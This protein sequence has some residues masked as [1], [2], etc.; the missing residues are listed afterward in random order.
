M[1]VV[2]TNVDAQV[3]LYALARNERTM[4]TAMERLSTG[5]RVNSAAD[6]PAGLQMGSRMTAQIRGLSRAISNAQDAVS[7][8]QTADQTMGDL[9]SIVQRIRELAVQAANGTNTTA[10]RLAI[11]TEMHALN[12]EVWRISDDTQFNGLHLANGT[13]GDPSG[14]VHFQIGANAGQSLSV[15]FNHYWELMGLSSYPDVGTM[16]QA[17]KANPLDFST[18]SGAQFGIV[19]NDGILNALST[20]RASVGAT[21]NRLDYSI[22][23]L[24]QTLV[25][26]TASRARVLDADYAVQTANLARSQII[27]RAGLAVLAHANQR[28]SSVLELLRG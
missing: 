16:I 25:N 18:E 24:T 12:S 9:Q 20:V 10:D 7:M 17:L 26:A 28:P 1:T 23:N 19:T 27:N 22:A 8:L 3:T 21:L 14:H 11:N 5:S 2:N 6:D 15:N 13:I 4:G